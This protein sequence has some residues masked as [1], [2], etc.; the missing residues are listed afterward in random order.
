M[1]SR[2][3]IDVF[4]IC[5]NNVSFVLQT[6]IPDPPWLKCADTIIIAIVFIFNHA[7]INNRYMSIVASRSSFRYSFELR[8]FV[9]TKNTPRYFSTRLVVDIRTWYFNETSKDFISRTDALARCATAA[10][11]G[12]CHETNRE[13]TLSDSEGYITGMTPLDRSFAREEAKRVRGLT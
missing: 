1:Y 2:T 9:D 10:L 3:I 13:F 8:I 11:L 7:F 6:F 5:Q 4:E 12:K